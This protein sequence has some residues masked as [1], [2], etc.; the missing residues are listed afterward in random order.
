MTQLSWALSTHLAPPRQELNLEPEK[1]PSPEHI[2]ALEGLSDP[3]EAPY[4]K[5]ATK[6]LF[7]FGV[8]IAGLQNKRGY[9]TP[10]LSLNFWK[11]F[12]LVL[13]SVSGASKLEVIPILIRK[14]DMFTEEPKH[15]FLLDRPGKLN[16]TVMRIQVTAHDSGQWTLI[17]AK[18]LVVNETALALSKMLKSSK[19]N[20][21]PIVRWEDASWHLK[22]TTSKNRDVSG[23]I[24][25][26]VVEVREG[27]KLCLQKPG[28]QIWVNLM[29]ELESLVKY[30]EL[31]EMELL[32]DNY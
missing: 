24:W 5:Q 12:D 17:K 30:H 6:A 2:S 15:E 1:G 23:C 28:K 27:T 19:D 3:K 8:G 4:A 13:P 9:R 22:W 26:A 32:L 31:G 25:F 16:A 18:D 11:T 14:T 20:P 7:Q 10:E 29:E 21:P